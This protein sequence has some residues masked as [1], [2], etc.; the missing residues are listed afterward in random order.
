[1]KTYSEKAKIWENQE[2][3]RYYDSLDREDEQEDIPYNDDYDLRDEERERR[4]R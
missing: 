1:M 3:Q 2:L 4:G